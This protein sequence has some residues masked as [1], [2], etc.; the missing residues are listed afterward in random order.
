MLVQNDFE[1]EKKKQFV[2]FRKKERYTYILIFL[3]KSI[4]LSLERMAFIIRGNGL[5]F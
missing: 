1:F 3:S 2:I 4:E 5:T